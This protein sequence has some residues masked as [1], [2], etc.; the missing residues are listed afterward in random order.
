MHAPRN[1]ARPAPA[2]N[3]ALGETGMTIVE[4]AIAAV[5]LVVSGL[6]VL[7]LVDAAS[8]NDFRATQSQVV[9]DRLQQEM[10]AIKELP[11]NQVALT[12]APPHSPDSTNPN[13]RVTGTQ[14][15][16]NE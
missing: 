11:Y 14:F 6:A 10:E 2:R 12:G 1:G 7:G 16:V 4:V 3:R 13:F 9:N 5:I 15:N 8:R